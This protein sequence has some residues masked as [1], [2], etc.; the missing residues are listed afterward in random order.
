MQTGA[1]SYHSPIELISG[2][3]RMEVECE[4]ADEVQLFILNDDAM[5]CSILGLSPRLQL[6]ET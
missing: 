5:P 3:L 4:I 6:E 2:L 1:K